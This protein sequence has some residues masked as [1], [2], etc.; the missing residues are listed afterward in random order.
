MKTLLGVDIK[1]LR[2]DPVV[3]NTSNAVK[4]SLALKGI[5]PLPIS[6][7]TPEQNEGAERLNLTFRDGV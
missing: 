2:F 7:N 5:Q 4:Q 6:S 1:T 3:E